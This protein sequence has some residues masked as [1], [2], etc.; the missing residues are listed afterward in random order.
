LSYPVRYAVKNFPLNLEAR[1]LGGSVRWSPANDLDDATSYHPVFTGSTDINFTVTHILPGGCITTDTQP[2]KM[3]EK[4]GIF[5]PTGF[6]PNGD[7]VNEILKPILVGMKELDYFKVF[8]RWGQLLFETKS[9][10][11]GWDGR[12]K[13]HRL[14]TQVITWIAQGKGYDGKIYLR[15]GTTLL[16]R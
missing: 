3:A 5:V 8:N 16:L 4:P 10:G 6:S 13:G 7:G 2:V 11:L 15:K 9:N 1:N 14:E 12:L